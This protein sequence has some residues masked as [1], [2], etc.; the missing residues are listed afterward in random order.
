MFHSPEQ[1]TPAGYAGWKTNNPLSNHKRLT[2]EALDTLF[3]NTVSFF[4]RIKKFQTERLGYFNGDN[5]LDLIDVD[6]AWKLAETACENYGWK[7][8]TSISS[9]NK[10]YRTVEYV[11]DKTVPSTRMY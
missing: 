10:R 7:D 3:K 6:E 9:D 4:A 2:K 5:G 11:K 8:D 1:D